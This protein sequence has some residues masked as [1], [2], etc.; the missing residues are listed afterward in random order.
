MGTKAKLTVLTVLVL[1]IAGFVWLAQEHQK[2]RF[3]SG[4]VIDVKAVSAL[5]TVV[6]VQER[7]EE[8]LLW[9]D[10]PYI[11]DLLAAYRWEKYDFSYRGISL[12]GINNL[13]IV[14]FRTLPQRG[15]F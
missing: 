12:F 8:I 9:T 13:K 11:R 3:V 2:L 10:N 14:K 5:N 7:G 1:I 6:T 15:S 4:I